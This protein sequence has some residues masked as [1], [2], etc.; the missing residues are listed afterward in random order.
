MVQEIDYHL[1]DMNEQTSLFRSA[2]VP[3][4]ILSIT[5]PKQIK[6]PYAV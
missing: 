3:I 5:A 2:V 1:V 6:D 4:K